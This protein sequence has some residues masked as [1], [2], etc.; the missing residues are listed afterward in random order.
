MLSLKI[1]FKGSK[2]EPDLLF[3]AQICSFTGSPGTE[4]LPGGA[5][6]LHFWMPN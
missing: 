2:R 5:Y 4:D 1:S 3:L 6:K